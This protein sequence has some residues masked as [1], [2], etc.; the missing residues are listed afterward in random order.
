MT[1]APKRA[2]IT[3]PGCGRICRGLY[4]CRDCVPYLRPLRSDGA[5]HRHE[6]PEARREALRRTWREN[7]RRQYE[8]YKDLCDSFGIRRRGKKWASHFAELR[9]W[10]P[11]NIAF[12]RHI[13]ADL[14]ERTLPLVRWWLQRFPLDELITMAGAL[15]QLDPD[16]SEPAA[17]RRRAA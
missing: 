7:S 13:E 6:T 4:G 8:A 15:D 5:V 3:C 1:D 9:T 10:V 14:D 16:H 11:R 2:R 17:L 12:L